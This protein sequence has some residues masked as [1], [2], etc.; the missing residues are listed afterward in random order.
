MV[1]L[2]HGEN[3]LVDLGSYDLI[4]T[5]DHVLVPVNLLMFGMETGITTLT[6]LIE[7]MSW[8]E[9]YGYSGEEMGRL[10]GAYAPYLLV[11]MLVL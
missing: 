8:R 3:C 5:P 7:M 11:G 2:P 4:T 1:R 6:C 10:M 9:R